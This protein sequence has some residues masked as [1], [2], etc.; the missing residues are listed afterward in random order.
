MND[1]GCDWYCDGC[2]IELN[3]QSGFTVESGSWT[4]EVCGYVNDVSADNIISSEEAASKRDSFEQRRVYAD[5][6][7][8]FACFERVLMTHIAHETT[9]ADGHRHPQQG[10]TLTATKA[11][12]SLNQ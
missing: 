5:G 4:C 6:W 1:G 3:S 11:N 9:Q 12:R 2:S 7:H 8:F 10:D